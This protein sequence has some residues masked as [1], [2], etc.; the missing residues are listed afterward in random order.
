M[1]GGYTSGLVKCRGRS[2]HCVHCYSD[3][4]QDVDAGGC[5]NV[6]WMP[7]EL[8]WHEKE[9]AVQAAGRRPGL[10][11]DREKLGHEISMTS[12]V[13]DYLAVL[14]NSDEGWTIGL[15]LPQMREP[16][17]GDRTL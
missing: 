3:E 12:N 13:G 9:Q 7:D 17:F 4:A 14:I 1:K 8:Q 2:C 11:G 5:P 16:S 10:R 15:V 6:D